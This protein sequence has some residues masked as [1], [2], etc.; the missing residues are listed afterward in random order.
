MSSHC[1]DSANLAVFQK[2]SLFSFP[3]WPQSATSFPKPICINRLRSF[4]L[5][6]QATI[7]FSIHRPSKLC[8]NLNQVFFTQLVLLLTKIVSIFSSPCA[9]FDPFWFT[10]RSVDKIQ[11]LLNPLIDELNPT[12]HLL[13]L[14]GTHP[15]LHVSRI[16]VNSTRFPS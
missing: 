13:A 11:I 14:L 15:I 5:S 4:F 1:T 9:L 10:T 2:F 12:C 16:R 8:I 3:S 7:Y 6:Q